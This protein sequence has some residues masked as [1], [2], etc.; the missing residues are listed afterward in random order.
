MEQ[1][2]VN[3]VDKRSP[4]SVSPPHE[5]SNRASVSRK[6]VLRDEREYPIDDRF[7]VT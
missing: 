2:L 5:A 4:S 7:G 3:Q 1:S 6:P